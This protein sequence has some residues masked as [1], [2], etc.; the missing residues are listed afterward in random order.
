LANSISCNP[1]LAGGD[2]MQFD[3]LKRREFI[4]LLGGW[5]AVRCAA[6]ETPRALVQI[7]PRLW[8]AIL[9]HCR[10]NGRRQFACCR[11]HLSSVEIRAYIALA[12]S[13]HGALTRLS[14]SWTR[15][16]RI[17]GLRHGKSYQ[18]RRRSSR[19]VSRG[20]GTTL[21]TGSVR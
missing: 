3:Q 19:A 16:S 2:R 10:R 7:G 1:A 11:R 14:F 9:D 13:T 20:G 12:E 21:S 6:R 8:S 4:T 17:M 15:P 18:A 5:R